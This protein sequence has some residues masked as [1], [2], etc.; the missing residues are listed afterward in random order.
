MEKKGWQ[1]N[2]NPFTVAPKS[3]LERLVAKSNVRNMRA[4]ASWKKS[5]SQNGTNKFNAKGTNETLTEER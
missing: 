5:K 1:T 4:V 3:M 2:C